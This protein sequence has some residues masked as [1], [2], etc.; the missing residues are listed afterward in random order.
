MAFSYYLIQEGKRLRCGYTTGTCAALAAQ[1]AAEMLFTGGIS[2][3]A[4]LV[5]PKGL[6]VSA[7]LLDIQRKENSVYCAVEKDAGDDID[8]TNGLLIG[9]EV[10]K[11]EQAGVISIDGGKG[12][13]RVTRRGLEQPIG[14]AAINSGP[15]KMILEEVR[16]VCD[17]YAYT[18]GLLVLITV[19][20]GEKAAQKTFNPNL[21]ITGGISILGTSGIVEPKSQKALLASIRLE[22]QYV[23]ANGYEDIILTP[24][25]YG[26]DFLKQYPFLADI[27]VIKCANFIGD[28]LECMAGY[29]FRHILLV[30]HIGKLVKVAGGILNTHSANGDCRMELLGVHAAVHGAD[31][32][33]VQGIMHCVTTE[34]ALEILQRANIL[35]A[36][37]D[38][39]LEK[40]QLYIGRKWN[41]SR[42]IADRS[43]VEGMEKDTAIGA[44]LYSSRFGL[45]GYSK[46]G[47]EI[48]SQ[49]KNRL[50]GI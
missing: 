9:A 12:V 48:L 5:T 33:T 34:E 1:G 30:G 3:E 27:P 2:T 6:P 20:E 37:T 41:S 17:K 46:E 39:L 10:R 49:W 47:Q 43:K 45:L 19:P 50:T 38:A 29:S 18:G 24:G 22:I 8:A 36:V 25:N 13:G 40:I 15:R 44:V 35:P 42:V 23:K 32:E 4:S 14:A 26:A 31:Q 16:R 21:G 28:A 7:P 11:T